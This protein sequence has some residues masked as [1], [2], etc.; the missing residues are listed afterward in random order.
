MRAA[1]YASEEGEGKEGGISV[2]EERRAA[3][4]AGEH[5]SPDAYHDMHRGGEE[6]TE[7][8]SYRGHPNAQPGYLQRDL[9]CFSSIFN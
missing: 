9:L 5:A 8:P 7:P 6:D 4:E 1:G 3:E 2:E